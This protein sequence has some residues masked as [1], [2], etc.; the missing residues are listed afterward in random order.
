MT[1]FLVTNTAP[2]GYELTNIMVFG[3]WTDGGRNEQKYQVL[4]STAATPTTFVPLLTA[5]YNPTDASGA[6]S[7]TRTSLVPATGV[8]AH[9]VVAVKFNFNVSPAPKNNWEGYSEIM[10]RG[11]PSVGVAPPLTSDISPQAAFDVV[12]GQLVM[13]A[14][15]S[16][17]TSLQ[18]KKGGVAIPGATTPTLTLNNLQLSDGAPYTLVASNAAGAT[19][20][21]ACVLTVNPVPAPVSN[22]VVAYAGQ[23]APYSTFSPTWNASSLTSSLIYNTAPSSSGNGDFTGFFDNAFCSPNGALVLTDGAFGTND[24]PVTGNDFCFASTGSN[25]GAGNFVTYSLTGSSNGYTITNI[26]TFGGWNDGG[27]DEQAY[28]VSYATAAN[29]TTFIPLTSADIN[30]VSPNGISAD[31]VTITAAVGALATNV[32]A[33]NFDFTLPAGENGWS[34]YS[35]ISAFGFASLPNPPT[36]TSVVKSG[37][38]LIIVGS[39]GSPN[40]GYTWLSTTNLV[41]PN[42]ITNSTGTFDGSGAFS[43]SIPINP[44]LPAN[45]FRVRIP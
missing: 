39:G 11:T 4:Y 27:R 3:G 42:W 45:Y 13:T 28:T 14:S 38:N 10:V 26:T 17:Y 40:A 25:P 6:A 32:V 15:F 23:T 31:R 33:L 18:W 12:G 35:E 41:T 2:S 7:A 37:G 44:A 43:N 24:F 21:S 30:P 20:S 1:Y 19:S 16:N 5:D 9:N 22:I 36:I 29:P 8:L 34:G